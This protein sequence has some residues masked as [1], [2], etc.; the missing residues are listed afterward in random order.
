MSK[1]EIPPPFQVQPL[2]KTSIPDSKIKYLRPYQAGASQVFAYNDYM[3]AYEP[4]SSEER[5]M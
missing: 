3:H 1:T 5:F 4:P 2:P